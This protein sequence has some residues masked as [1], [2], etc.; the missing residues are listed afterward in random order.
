MGYKTFT[1]V[2][3]VSDSLLRY[4]K[5]DNWQLYEGVVQTLFKGGPNAVDREFKTYE[6]VLFLKKKT[7]KVTQNVVEINFLFKFIIKYIFLLLVIFFDNCFQM[8]RR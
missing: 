2:I 8:Y 6:E 4:Q 7:V 3:E 1:V 5:Y